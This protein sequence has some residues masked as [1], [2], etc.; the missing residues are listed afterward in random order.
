MAITTFSFTKD[1]MNPTDFPTIETSEAQVRADLQ[2]L[3]NE[4]RDKINELIGDYNVTVASALTNA[5]IDA[6]TQ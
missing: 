6:A 3:H 2:I 1:W 5:D 4:T